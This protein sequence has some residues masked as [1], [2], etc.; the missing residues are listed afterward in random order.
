MKTIAKRIEQSGYIFRNEREQTFLMFQMVK[1]IEDE[2]AFE[3]SPD[4]NQSIL[5]YECAHTIISY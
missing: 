4:I 5:I 1:G 2:L 3:H